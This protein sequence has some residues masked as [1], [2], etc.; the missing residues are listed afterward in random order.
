MRVVLVA[1]GVILLL[2]APARHM[3]GKALFAWPSND[4]PLWL[5]ALG[6]LAW[7]GYWWIIPAS[8]VTL[9]SAALFMSLGQRRPPEN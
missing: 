7:S 9:L 8:G 6:S 5:T 2:L 1:I 3:A 4:P